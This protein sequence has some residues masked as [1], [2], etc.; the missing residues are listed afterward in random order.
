MWQVLTI[1]PGIKRISFKGD[2]T[3]IEVWSTGRTG[4]T[5]LGSES[6]GHWKLRGYKRNGVF[7]RTIRE[8][9]RRV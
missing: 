8:L 4:R 1:V 6:V 5:M 7:A 3:K 9:T 2:V